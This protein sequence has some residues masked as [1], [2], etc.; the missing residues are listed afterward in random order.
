MS[1]GIF[2]IGTDT[3]VGKTVV[4]AGLMY[5]LLKNKYRAAY[6]KPVASGEVE[7]GGGKISADAAF[8]GAVSGFSEKPDRVTPFAFAD[9]V[10]PH[11][12]ARLASRRIDPAVIQKSFTDLKDRY[13]V[14][15]GEGAGGLAVPLNDEGYMQYDLIRELNFPCLLVSRAGLGTINHTLLTLSFAKSVGLTVKGIVISGAGQTPVE[16]DNMA[17]IQKLSGIEAVFKLPVI[18]AVDTE[19]LQSGNLKDIF[20]QSVPLNDIVHLMDIL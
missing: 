11:L 8:V 16:Q 12:A 10:A 7:A 9:A 17:M 15:I 5:L 13:D 20:D 18:T 19:S 1:R 4:S 14:I 3:E 2:I 6:F